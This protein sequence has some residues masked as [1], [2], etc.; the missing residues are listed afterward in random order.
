[1]PGIASIPRNSCVFRRTARSATTTRWRSIGLDC[2][3]RQTHYADAYVRTTWAP[4]PKRG[5]KGTTD[6]LRKPDKLISY[7][8]G[9]TSFH[10][11]D[12]DQADRCWFLLVAG[13]IGA[14][15]MATVLSLLQFPCRAQSRA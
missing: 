12:P 13:L 14:A 6:V 15:F 4:Q 10:F 5:H 8:H 3:S 1:M 9:K 7:R 2:K 11:D